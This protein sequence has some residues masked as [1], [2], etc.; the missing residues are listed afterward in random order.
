M[1]GGGAGHELAYIHSV[2]FCGAG[3][4]AG[5]CVNYCIVRDCCKN[6]N[7][8]RLCVYALW[9]V[10]VCKVAGRDGQLECPR[11]GRGA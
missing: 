8:R 6:R 5:L 3:G 9:G 1:C 4:G 7:V 10:C 11:G 2:C